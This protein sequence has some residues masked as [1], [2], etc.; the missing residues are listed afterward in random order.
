MPPG[1]HVFLFE[2]YADIMSNI[3]PDSL[4][5]HFVPRKPVEEDLLI[6]D[7]YLFTHCT[8]VWILD[9]E[10]EIMAVFKFVKS[11]VYEQSQISQSEKESVAAAYFKN[12]SFK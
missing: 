6:L 12:R 5:I 10:K 8:S 2:K 4:K 1:S 9:I 3:F 7:G 11:N